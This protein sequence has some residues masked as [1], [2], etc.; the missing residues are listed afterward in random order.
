MKIDYIKAE[1]H[2]FKKAQLFQ[3]KNLFKKIDFNQFEITNINQ[4]VD[5]IKS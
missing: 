5:I 3:D 2:T 4:K 1:L